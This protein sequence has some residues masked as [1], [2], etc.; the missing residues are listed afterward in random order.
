M[1]FNHDDFDDIDAPGL[2]DLRAVAHDALRQAAVAVRL[3][4]NLADAASW[5]AA[6]TSVRTAAT[7][8][9]LAADALDREARAETLRL[10]ARSNGTAKAREVQAA[11]ALARMIHGAGLRSFT[12]T[13]VLR[14]GARHLR[15]AADV[16]AA[17]A[18]L[19]RAGWFITAHRSAPAGGGDAVTR[20]FVH[21]R[22]F[23]QQ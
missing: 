1:S 5:S 4:T 13:E 12:P 10:R 20:Y 22:V 7:W 8:A 2:D 11:R 23:A 18:A 19:D 14:R 9:R 15:S 3:A 6:A 17:I 16:R 21:P